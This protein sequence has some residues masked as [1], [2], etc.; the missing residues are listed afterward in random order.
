[1]NTTKN[2]AP[3]ANASNGKESVKT[4]LG[5][6]E[7]PLVSVPKVP[8]IPVETEKSTTS[9]LPP[10]EDRIL[11]VNQLASLVEKHE[12]L[13]ETNKKLNSFKLSSDGSRDTLKITDSKGNDF[14]TSNSG[15]IADV[16]GLLKN[17][18][19]SKIKEVEGLIRF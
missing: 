10:V 13:L 9:N 4:T 16:V 7:T 3:A 1:M 12:T 2:A 11:K 18:I 8:Q 17:S 5:Q 6:K 19:E 15:C 14:T